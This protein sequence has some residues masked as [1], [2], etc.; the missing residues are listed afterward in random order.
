MEKEE[1]VYCHSGKLTQHLLRKNKK[2]FIKPINILPLSPRY[3]FADGLLKYKK[4]NIDG[5]IK[6]N[7]SLE[8]VFN[9]SK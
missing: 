3:N 4:T 7:I 9:F 8:K 1:K 6:I 2:P 5:K